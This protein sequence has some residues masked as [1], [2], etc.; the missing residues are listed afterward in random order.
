MSELTY[1]QH[2]DYLYPNL[3]SDERF[4]TYIDTPALLKN[5]MLRDGVHPKLENYKI[6]VDELAKTNI[7]I[8]NSRVTNQ[9]AEVQDLV[10]ETSQKIS[11]S[12]GLATVTYKGAALTKNYIL[13]GR[14][15]ITKKT[16]NAHVQFGVID[17]GD[18]RILLWDHASNG[19]FKLCIP[20]D[21]N[22]PE[23]DIY[24]L[25]SS[26]PI[27]ID[28][29]I[30]YHNNNVYFFIGDELK[31]VYT[32]V[33]NTEAPLVLGSEGAACSFYNMRAVT[34]AA[35]P[36]EYQQN[37]DSL[38]ATISPYVGISTAQKIRA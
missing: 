13:S 19:Q 27:V 35:N 17:S 26:N 38:Y 10:F 7:S 37:I 2:G 22:V 6:F 12:T 16:T 14:L 11:D 3:I 5:D 28:F 21:T 24:T 29:K 18:N 23:E 34:L 20:Y 4:I 15:E 1:I 33:G 30:V 32:A 36:A 8:R 31:I 25:K 9:S